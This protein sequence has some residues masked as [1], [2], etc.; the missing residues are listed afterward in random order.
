M[1]TAHY[2]HRLPADY[3]L[4]AIRTRGKAR[5][6]LWDAAPELYFK[7]FLLREAGKHGAIENSYSSLY[8]WRSDQAFA[9]F[10]LADR[11]RNVTNSFGR[12]QIETRLVLDA[13]RGR[14]Q[15]TQFV[16]EETSD[17]ARDADL[18]QVFAAEVVQNKAAVTRPGVVAAVVS[19][20]TLNWRVSRYLLAEH[21]QA[22]PSDVAI[23]YE[24][25]HLSQP[26]LHTLPEGQST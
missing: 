5:G 1:L 8:L 15:Q 21:A 11:Y 26:L 22:R 4:N 18:G 7:G 12:A 20:D 16:F 13:H 10:L 25:V 19:L 3:D 17:I 9:D 24:V 2:L 6:A 14:A 23:A